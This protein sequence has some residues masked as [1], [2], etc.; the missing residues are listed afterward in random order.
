MH[1]TTNE[2]QDRRKKLV[3]K[4]IANKMSHKMKPKNKQE[5]P[6]NEKDK[7]YEYINKLLNYGTAG[8]KSLNLNNQNKTLQS[9]LQGKKNDD[10]SLNLS[11][12]S[13]K[14]STD[15]TP[16]LQNLKKKNN[17]KFIKKK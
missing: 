14:I 2:L 13:D 12:S 9:N 1:D 3:D 11:K 8:E 4:V 5:K 17:I 6:Q 15:L 7:K 16:E 10:N